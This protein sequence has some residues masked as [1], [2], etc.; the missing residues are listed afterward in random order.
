M[1]LATLSGW[2]NK[3]RLHLDCGKY[4][5]INR[6][7]FLISEAGP[8]FEKLLATILQW[9]HDIQHDYTKRDDIQ[10]A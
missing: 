6:S 3:L 2:R 10:H 8:L 1:W 4:W 9:K 7:V 5:T